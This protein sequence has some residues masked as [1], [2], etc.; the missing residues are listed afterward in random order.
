MSHIDFK[1][2]TE[3]PHFAGVFDIHP[4]EVFELAEHLHLVDVREHS[5]WISELGH[6]HKAELISLNSIPEKLDQIPK[7]KTLVF[8][9]RSGGRSAKAAA[10]A[11]DNGYENVYNM[12]GGMLLWNEQNLPTKKHLD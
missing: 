2:K 3:N 10:F 7:D 9:C 5:E 8:I 6:F 4:Q 11:L 1:T 12:V